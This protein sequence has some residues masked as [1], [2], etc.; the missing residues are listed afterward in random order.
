MKVLLINPPR[1]NE[2]I[3]NNPSIIEEERGHN[4]PLGILYL[5][6][7]LVKHTSHEVEI[8]DAQVENVSYGDLRDRVL[9]ARPDVVGITT[10][11]L[12]L[13]DVLKTVTTV[14]E[15][16]PETRIVLG[17]PHVHLFP[18]ETIRLPGVDYLVLGEGEE[19]LPE[20]LDRLDDRDAL[21]GIPGLVFHDGEEIVNTGVRPCIEDLDALPFPARH[22]TPYEKYGSLLAAGE[23][24]TTTFTSRGCPFRCTFC[25]RPHLGKRFRARSAMNVV[26][27]IQECVEMG[28][29]DFLIYDDTFTIKKDRTIDICDEIVRRGLKIHFDIRA[30]VDTTDDVLLGRLKAAG[31]RGIHYG[32]EAGT[33]HILKILNKGITLERAREAF[34]LTRKHKIPILAYFMIGNPGETLEDIR[35]TFKVMRQLSPDFVHIT[36]LTP[37]P[38]TQIYRD[39]LE[40][41][42]IARDV[43]REFAADPDPSFEPPHWGENFTRP[44]LHELL[45]QGYKGF[46]MRPSYVI[47]R[48]TQVR[49]WAEFKRKAKAGLAVFGMK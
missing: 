27:E 30:R 5:A 1:E 10:M 15:T 34:S 14:K 8:L 18:D 21:R 7:Y 6:G 31:C 37:F 35:T 16:L 39:G 44:E 22:L 48:V 26:D 11:T 43:W 45:A 12:T 23:V 33:A 9:A 3:G 29:R 32:I 19:V 36:V 17:G 13:I 24:V 46:Y 25:D 2:I 40:R 28:I 38:G 47:R 41:G 4:P 42:I 20:L 49:S